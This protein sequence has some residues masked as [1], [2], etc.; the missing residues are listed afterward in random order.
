MKK[1]IPIIVILAILSCD[2]Q[3][4]KDRRKTDQNVFQQKQVKA[5]IPKAE[6][7]IHILPLGDVP[8]EYINEIKSVVKMDMPTK[9]TTRCRF[10]LPTFCR[11]SLTTR[12]LHS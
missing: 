9:L 11:Y 8:T 4:R 10:I 7:L 12:L 2:H 6:K 1:F 3:T 5:P